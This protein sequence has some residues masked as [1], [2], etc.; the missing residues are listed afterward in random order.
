M[1][2]V[3]NLPIL[4]IT[5]MM[6]SYLFFS[7]SLKYNNRKSGL[8]NINDGYTIIY[9]SAKVTIYESITFC[10]FVLFDNIY[11]AILTNSLSSS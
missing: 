9:E 3:D 11:I 2:F 6:K 4:I 8:A 1:N 5:I 10:Q 7:V